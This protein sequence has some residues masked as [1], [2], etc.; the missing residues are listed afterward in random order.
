MTSAT[1]GS[2]RALF[3][4][5]WYR[6]LSPDGRL[7]FIAAWGG[8]ALAGF[9]FLAFTFVLAP[10]R[11]AFGL[12]EGQIGALATA[13]LMASVAGGIAGGVLADRLGRARVLR[14]SIAAYALLSFLS[15]LAQSYEQLLALRAL[16]GAGF[17]A[18]WT[19]GALLV[20][21]YAAPAQ[22]GRT[23]GVYTAGF[24][25]GDGLATLAYF[26]ITALVPAALS[27]RVLFWLGVLP[28][29]LVLWAR[30]RVVDPPAYRAAQAHASAGTGP[31]PGHGSLGAIFVPPL[32]V[33]TVGGSLL[34]SGILS[35]KYIV[36]IWLPGYLQQ[37]RGL[38][39]AAAAIQIGVVLVG[40]VLGCIVGGYCQDG[41]GRRRTFLLYSLASPAA[42]WLYLLVPAGLAWLLLVVG[43]LVGFCTAGALSGLG[44]YLAELYPSAH[45]GAGQG[46]TYNL[47][48]GAS[49]L[50]AGGIGLLAPAIDL[51]AAMAVGASVYL[52]ALAG[53]VLLPETRG[54]DLTAHPAIAPAIPPSASAQA[55]GAE[56]G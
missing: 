53:L 55:A 26:V 11:A 56:P 51:N 47:G 36:N 49:G 6:A 12:S 17:G 33:A 10:I 30:T 44:A 42:L 35:G 24:S 14:W 32:L 28:A 37:W 23:Q 25:V 38:G 43:A 46:V 13:S 41:L 34:A 48:R 21:E 52:V 40:A 9:D 31:A 16:L 3:T 5:D 39:S 4:L 45:R 15:G 8:Y 2:A 29:L 22:R 54:R 50:V 1:T 7:A 27:W 18:E 20:A 19:A